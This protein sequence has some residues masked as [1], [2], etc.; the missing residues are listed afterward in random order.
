MNGDSVK[1]GSS[2][3]T[4]SADIW[5]GDARQGTDTQTA[6]PNDVIRVALVDDH[7]IMREGLVHTFERDPGFEV[8][9]QGET[10]SEAIQIA[11]T[12]LPDLIFLDINMPGDGVQAARAISRSC[13]AVRI[14]MLTAHESEHHVVDALRSGAS[15]Y[16]VKG[17][18][19]EDLIKTAHSIHEGE[20]YV[21]PALAAKLLGG[22][23]S[24][25]VSMVGA[26]SQKFVDLTSREEQILRLVC[27]G[28]SNKEIGD[29]IGLTE[30]TVKHYMTNILQ[31]LHA[32]NR[33]EA[34]LIAREHL[35]QFSLPPIE[36]N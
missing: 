5:S 8:V 32:R 31:K 7:P 26:N 12:M 11:E 20:A 29:T 34:A 6:R 22:R 36:E 28:Q 10:G 13:P 9:G 25:V 2:M 24:N 17:I 23:R 30:K 27:Q 1:V 35:T 33:L 3:R 16:V 14:I 21:S 18:S 19:S 4:S 15:G